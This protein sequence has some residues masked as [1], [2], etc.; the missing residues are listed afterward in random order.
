MKK[1]VLILLLISIIGGSGYCYWK[2]SSIQQPTEVWKCIP[3]SASI[4][5]E[6]NSPDQVLTTWQKTD[7]W[8]NIAPLPHP[9]LWKNTV[10]RLDSLFLASNIAGSFWK[11]KTVFVS[12]HITG[13]EEINYLFCLDLRQEN[14]LAAHDEI[15]AQIRTN[16]DFR[17][18][19]RL[20]QQMLIT[21]ISHVPSGLKMSATVYK[22]V[23]AVSFT[24]VL[25]EDFIRTINRANDIH[26]V[27]N[28]KDNF[29]AT[30]HDNGNVIAYINYKQLP[31]LLSIASPLHK[32]YF[33]PLAYVAQAATLELNVTQNKS[34]ATG[35]SL[36]DNSNFLSVFAPQAPQPIQVQDFI[37]NRTAVLYHFSFSQGSKLGSNWD[38]YRHRHLDE[39]L[40]GKE[41]WH[42]NQTISPG[43][44]YSWWGREIALCLL[45]TVEA[46]EADKLLFIQ[47]TDREQTARTL[48]RIDEKTKKDPKISPYKEQFQ[49]YE[50]RQ[51][52]I[53]NF[54]GMLLGNPFGG[55]ADCFYTFTGNYVVFGNN[56]Q[57]LRNLITDIDNENVWAKSTKHQN[58]LKELSPKSHVTMVV[59]TS[60]AWSLLQDNTGEQWGK[61]LLNQPEPLQNIAWIGAQYTVT[62]TKCLTS[63]IL[64]QQ[65][66][67]SSS[68][69][70]EAIAIKYDTYFQFSPN[71]TPKVIR[72][73]ENKALESMI[74]DSLHQIFLLNKE[75]NITFKQP[76][77]Q[78]IISDIIPLQLAG[79]KEQQFAFVTDKALYVLDRTGAIIPSF[80]VRL[81]DSSRIANLAIFDYEKNNNYRFLLANTDGLLFMFDENGKILEG[82]NPR[83]LPSKLA[84]NPIHLT[85]NEKDCIVALTANGK[86]YMLTRK[87]EL[88]AG[89][90]VDLKGRFDSQLLFEINTDFE[91][92]LITMLSEQGEL[93]RCNLKGIEVK[94]EQIYRPSANTYFTLC[95]EPTGKTFAIARQTDNHIT[96]FDNALKPVFE[97]E[98]NNANRLPVQFYY[99]GSGNEVFIIN[100]P[101]A[102]KAYIYNKVG[103]LMTGKPIESS[104]LV[105][106]LYSES[107][108]TFFLYRNFAKKAGLITFKK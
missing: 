100:E 80:P 56:I 79:N 5:L 25:V 47:T 74:I 52:P 33:D 82:W 64:Q 30:P 46:D 28:Q 31:A 7:F 2:W 22:N 3:E 43:Q 58:F 81:P 32:S 10:A 99:F 26:F 102:E 76:I 17:V 53:D 66:E 41:T 18:Q 65:T 57:T 67:K 6:I 35:F 88:Y 89:F 9:T 34:L 45:E 92:S 93:I 8:K 61:M 44:L 84:T 83:K 77:G 98:Y 70:N 63:I 16:K 4:V 1:L 13:K 90:P 38:G 48:A 108:E 73:P 68:E 36:I 62:E 103:N 11:D 15:L 40:A 87:G 50:I 107:A 20:Y 23:V 85:V 60:R 29:K 78:K 55:F 106:L 54:P 19:E 49:G 59:N 72:N 101:A 14:A 39:F 37:P 97:K 104:T 21:E 91:N 12:A 95:P 24:A 86:L 27:E 71:T 51:I 69:N 94:R 42:E 105:A 75:G 96:I